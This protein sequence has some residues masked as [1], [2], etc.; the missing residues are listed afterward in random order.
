MAA[1]WFGYPEMSA[2]TR[3]RRMG[4]ASGAILVVIAGLA[5][6]AVGF[7]HGCLLSLVFLGAEILGRIYLVMAGILPL[8]AGDAVKFVLGGV[9]ALAVI[10]ACV[11][12]AKKTGR[13][14]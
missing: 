1:V 8:K 10:S 14:V 7:K 11:V 13:G 2:L 3:V 4:I 12:A 5:E 9:A 6:V